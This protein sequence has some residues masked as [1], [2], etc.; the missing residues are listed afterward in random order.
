MKT[1]K[2]FSSRDTMCSIIS[3]HDILLLLSC[4]QRVENL[5]HGFMQS[6][7]TKSNR[8]TVLTPMSLVVWNPVNLLWINA[9]ISWSNLLVQCIYCF[10]LVWHSM[11]A[12]LLSKQFQFLQSLNNILV[13]YCSHVNELLDRDALLCVL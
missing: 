5:K 12:L 1:T 11:V 10:S 3:M 4:H 6:S 8:L 7:K 9:H 2:D 13:A